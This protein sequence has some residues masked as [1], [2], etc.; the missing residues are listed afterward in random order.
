MPS[1]PC[2]KEKRA[3]SKHHSALTFSDFSS[4]LLACLLSSYPCA[5][6]LAK[7]P[8]PPGSLLCFRS[9]FFWVFLWSRETGRIYI[10][11]C[12]SRAGGS[13]GNPSPCPQAST[14]SL[15]S[16]LD[17]HQAFDALE[18]PDKSDARLALPLP[19]VNSPVLFQDFVSQLRCSRAGLFWI[20]PRPRPRWLE[21]HVQC[22]LVPRGTRFHSAGH[23]AWPHGFR[24]GVWILLRVQGRRAVAELLDIGEE[25]ALKAH[26]GLLRRWKGALPHS[27]HTICH[28]L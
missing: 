16:R 9:G 21:V 26:V 25:G 23:A 11:L 18:R 3:I 27:C 6:A 28:H 15:N 8:F 1:E 13:W 4:L 5:K 2:S 10:W 20:Q 14:D 7:M 17:L 19:C 12:L 22:N 24:G